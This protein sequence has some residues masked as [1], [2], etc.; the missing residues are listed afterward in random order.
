[1]T[2]NAQVPIMAKS[3]EKMPKMTDSAVVTI[4]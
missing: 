3:L 2:N 1:M 4:C